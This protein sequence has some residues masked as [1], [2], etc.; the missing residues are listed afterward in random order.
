MDGG[1]GRGKATANAVVDSRHGDL[2][3]NG[4][5]L[6]LPPRRRA[7]L[8]SWFSSVSR[9]AS[10]ADCVGSKQTHKKR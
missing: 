7:V 8:G 5:E 2:L 10:A 3:A 4:A 9:V 1:V 6:T